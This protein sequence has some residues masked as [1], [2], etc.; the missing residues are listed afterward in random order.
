MAHVVLPVVGSVA[1][2][3]QELFGTASPLYVVLQTV[4]YEYT[5]IALGRKALS[6]LVSVS[7]G[8]T[9]GHQA[10]KDFG[11][12]QPVPVGH[13]PSL[14]EAKHYSLTLG[15]PVFLKDLLQETIELRLGP[16]HTLWVVAARHRPGE[17][18][19]AL[20]DLHRNWSIGTHEYVALGV[21]E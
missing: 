19:D 9:Q 11:V 15:H 5:L 3:F 1:L 4:T 10:G 18:Q 14:G 20:V 6:H 2:R 21:Y 16:L 8:R 7:D 12:A 13:T 17:T